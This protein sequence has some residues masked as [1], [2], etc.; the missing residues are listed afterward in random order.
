MPLGRPLALLVVCALAATAQRVDLFGRILDTTEGG[1]ADAAV[2]VVNEDTGFRRVT[3]S[4]AGGMYSVASL[5]PGSYKV[6]VRREGFRT[7]MRFGVRLSPSGATRADFILPV[8]SI[9]ETITVYGTAALV[10]HDDAS[11]GTQVDRGE[12]E[13]LPLNGR[14]LL[15]LLEFAP[16][17]NVIPATRGDAGQFTATGQ[18]PN[19]NYFTVDGMSAN[20]GVTAGGLPAQS[21]GGSLPALSAFGSMDSLIS[22]E[23]VQEVRVTT[24]TS[25]A[26]FGRLPGATVAV[27]S[28]SGSNDFH[29]ATTYRI[30][31]ELFNANDW[32]ANE[33][34][35]GRVPLRLHDFMQALGGPIKR[36]RTFFFLSYQRLHMVQPFVWLQPAPSL[37]ARR[38]AA[39]WAQPL[40]KLLPLPTGS[41]IAGGVGESVGHSRRPAGLQ[42]GGLRIDQALGSRVTLFGRYNDSPSHNEFGALA[43]NQLDLRSKSLTLGLNARVTANLILDVRA[44][45]SQATAESAWSAGSECA[46]QPLAEI[47]RGGPTPCDH[48]VRFSIGGIGQFVSGRE[49]LRRQR[50]FQSLQSASYR[51]EKHTI[52]A[53][54]DFRSLTAIRRDPTGSLALIADDLSVISDSRKLWISQATGQNGSVNVRETS[55]WLQDTWQ[56][57]ARLSIAAGLR[58]EFSPPPLSSDQTFFLDVTSNS[59]F[60]GRQ[61]LWKRATANF[62]PRVGAAWQLTGDGRTVLRAGGGLYYESSMSIATDVLNGGPLSISSLSSSAHSPA[63]SLL[64]YGFMPNLQLPRVW[65]WN[66]STERA[67]GT[68]SVFSLGYLGSGARGLIRREAGGPGST[69]TAILALTTNHGNSN[70]HALQAQYRRKLSRD[71]QVLATYTWSHSID[72]D[73]SDSFLLWVTPGSSDRGSS[74]F[75]LRHAWATSVTYEPAR[76]QGWALDGIFRTRSGFPIT[77]LQAEQYQGLTVMNAFR[78]NLVYGQPLWLSNAADAAGKRLNPAAFEATPAGQQGTLGRNAISGLGMWQV[79]LGVRREFRFA[80]QRRL[81][82]RIEAFNALNHPNF[83]DPSRYRNSPIFGQSP[84]MLNM[85]L[86]TGSPGSGLAPILQTGGPRSLQGTIRFQ[87]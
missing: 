84:S 58:W 27:S 70:Y 73:S 42:T 64:S 24:S 46:L 77:V 74:D 79:D 11:T 53:G 68:H 6:T 54:V 61:P 30:R 62:A 86:G 85:M 31:H 47:F 50:Q 48:L 55:I 36:N 3:L 19:T 2:T 32:F 13:R 80:E 23:A 14:G 41:S 16:G 17:T 15:T 5:Q 33:A 82:L 9:E 78:P 49:G 57:A 7:L 76:L 22:L 60:P 45:E 71:L 56:P 8:G 66:V 72:N 44:N 12:I 10:G 39:D 69:F 59:V 43:V 20:N 67:F 21:T 40:L 29:G 28:R 81:L 52:G 63:S 38:V 65:Q 35:Y 37:E 4:E 83:G 51:H 26:E 25:I 87:F 75:D 18:R 1:I 34:G